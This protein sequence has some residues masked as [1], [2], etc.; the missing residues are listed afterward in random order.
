MNNFEQYIRRSV[1]ISSS[2]SSLNQMFCESKQQLKDREMSILEV[3]VW[4]S[5][6]CL[7]NTQVLIHWDDSNLMRG[8]VFIVLISWFMYIQSVDEI[9]IT[10]S[11]SRSRMRNDIYK[12]LME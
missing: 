5:S 11:L 1:L 12:I 10:L 9:K 7:R 6:V 3:G 4:P 8:S 2:R